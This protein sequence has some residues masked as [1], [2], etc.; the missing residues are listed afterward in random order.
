MCPGDR[1]GIG[2]QITPK[3]DAPP[4]TRPGVAQSITASEAL[5]CGAA[6]HHHHGGRR[7]PP[8]APAPWGVEGAP[9]RRAQNS[10]PLRDRL[11]WSALAGRPKRTCVGYKSGDACTR[12]N[13]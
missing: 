2:R 11:S 12:L 8:P 13:D 9:R 1:P 6:H 3:R 4:Q 5:L 7:R 10:G